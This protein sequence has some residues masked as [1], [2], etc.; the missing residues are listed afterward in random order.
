MRE[1]PLTQG[2]VALVDD[3]DYEWLSQWKWCSTNNGNGNIYAIRHLSGK[4]PL[5]KQITLKMHVA[6]WEHHNDPV[7][8]GYTVDHID[9][10]ELNDQRLNLRLA[11]R[12]Q[13]MQNQGV[14]KNNTS[15]YIGV[16]KLGKKYSAHI[17]ANNVKIFLGSFTDPAEAARV[18]DAAAIEHYGEFAVLNFPAG[19]AGRW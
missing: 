18:R 8:E 13:Q 16:S 5:P 2:Q 3:E 6:I 12:T 11:T 14:R 7:P 17:R 9:R 1:I 10:N 15:G 4:Y 19:S